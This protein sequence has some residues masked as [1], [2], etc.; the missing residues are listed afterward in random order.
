MIAWNF[1]RRRGF[2]R[3]TE[4]IPM[5]ANQFTRAERA[6]ERIREQAELPPEAA[7]ALQELVDVVRSVEGR[8]SALE[9][10]G[11]IHP[12]AEMALPNR[13]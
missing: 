10:K 5:P 12:T 9:D 6:I 11:R 13:R 4:D 3:S 1:A 8:L 7:I 2:D